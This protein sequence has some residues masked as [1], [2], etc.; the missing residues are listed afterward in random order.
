M[1][2]FVNRLIAGLLALALS[3]MAPVAASAQSGGQGSVVNFNQAEIQAVIDDVSSV[4]G[5]TFIVDPN[6]RGR[7]TITSQAPLTPDHIC[8]ATERAFKAKGH[9]WTG[10]ARADRRGWRSSTT[11]PPPCW[12]A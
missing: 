8:D 3:A 7:V 5:Y 1:T 4:T 10:C 6:V 9:H 12:R 11:P 2:D